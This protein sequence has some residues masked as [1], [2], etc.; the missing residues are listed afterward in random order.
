MK[1]FI[2]KINLISN[3]NIKWKVKKSNLH[4]SKILKLNNTKSKKYLN[5]R[6]TL[7]LNDM[8]DLT[9]SW[10]KLMKKKKL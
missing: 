10:Y 9:F 6:P 2:K 7:S 5:W 1:N 4:E 3:F 8:I